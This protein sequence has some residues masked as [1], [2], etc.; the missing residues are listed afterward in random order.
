MPSANIAHTAA[1][2]QLAA[3]SQQQTHHGQTKPSGGILAVWV[4]SKAASIHCKACST[5]RAMA[6][7][8]PCEASAAAATNLTS[9]ALLG[10]I[11]HGAPAHS[12]CPGCQLL[13]VHTC[14]TMTATP[15]Q[16]ATAACRLNGMQLVSVLLCV[17]RF[18][19]QYQL[20][21][22]AEPQAAS[23]TPWHIRLQPF[24]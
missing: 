19:P 2:Q 13:L 5:S 1:A 8:L 22:H 6:L 18:T 23:R 9:T 12:A 15:W 20:C 4:R 14:E 24:R 3:T 11:A 17:G 16:T 7:Q 21:K 10:T